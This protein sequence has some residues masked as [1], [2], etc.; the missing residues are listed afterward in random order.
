MNDGKSVRLFL[1]D[2]TSGGLVTA[3]IINWTGYVRMAPIGL[4]L[5]LALAEMIQRDECS[6]TGIN[7]LIGEDHL[8]VGD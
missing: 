7:I 2:G 4:G 1:A 8:G 6:R 3:E 5:G